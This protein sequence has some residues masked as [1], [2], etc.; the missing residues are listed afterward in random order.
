MLQ[1]ETVQIQGS[2]DFFGQIMLHEPLR[3]GVVF[4]R[5]TK[6]PIMRI[7]GWFGG[8]SHKRFPCFE[9]IRG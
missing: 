2:T 5:A 6:E 7:M 8:I 3:D 9:Q 1:L 4:H